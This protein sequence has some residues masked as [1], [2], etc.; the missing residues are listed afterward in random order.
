MVWSAGQREFVPLLL[1]LIWIEVHPASGG[2]GIHDVENKA[3]W[4]FAWLARAGRPLAYTPTRL[5]WVASGRSSFP[6]NDPKL[7][8]LNAIGVQFAGGHLSL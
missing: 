8:A 6:P 7:R 4:L 5:V 2:S 3:R 1:G